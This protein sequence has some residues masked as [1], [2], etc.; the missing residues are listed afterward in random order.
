MARSMSRRR[1]MQVAGA[2]VAAAAGAQALEAD[3]AS[4][5]I[6]STVPT[7]GNASAAAIAP[8]DPQ[9]QRV[10]NQ[11]MALEPPKFIDIV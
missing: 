9:M 10:L 11:L 1:F 7:A 3:V 5:H 4:A 8:A 6:T 2:G